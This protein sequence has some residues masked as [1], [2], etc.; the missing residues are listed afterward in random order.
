MTVPKL[1]LGT[2]FGSDLGRLPL[3]KQGVVSGTV[4][5]DPELSSTPLR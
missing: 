1:L 2:H 4:T 5:R 3:P